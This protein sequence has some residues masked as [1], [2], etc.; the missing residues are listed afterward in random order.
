[1]AENMCSNDT[2]STADT[3]SNV[4]ESLK[5][6]LNYSIPEHSPLNLQHQLLAHHYIANLITQNLPAYNMGQ[7][8]I[9]SLSQSE[10]DERLFLL[11]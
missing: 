7:H 9:A 3:D 6:L 11:Y 10:Y 4:D 1:M 8:D 2:A 5:Q